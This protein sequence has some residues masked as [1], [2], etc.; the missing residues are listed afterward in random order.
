[1][2]F[3][4]GREQSGALVAQPFRLY[5]PCQQSQ[6]VAAVPLTVGEENKEEL[7]ADQL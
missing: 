7:D 6:E 4:L 2:P 1:M 5:N 3:P